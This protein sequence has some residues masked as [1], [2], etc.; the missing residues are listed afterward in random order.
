MNIN[1][2]VKKHY[3]LGCGLC[4]SDV[5]VDKLQM[6]EQSDGFPIPVPQGNFNGE[7]SG[8][9]KYCPGITV[10]LNQ[11]LRTKLEKFYGPLL[12]IKVGHAND[13]MIRFRGSSGGCLT[14]ILCELINQGKVDCVLQAG[15]SE[16]IPTRTE[17]YLSKS[18]EEI[19][20]NA[21]SRYAP[22]SLLANF[23]QILDENERIAVVG[24]PCD[25]V[26]V[27]QY[28]DIHPEYAQK[29]FCTLSFMCMGL[30]SQN[31]TNLLIEK[32]GINDPKQ[33][34]ELRYR[35][36]G[37]PGKATVVNI[38]NQIFS[39]SYNESW[40]KILG[41]DVHFRCKIC[42]DGWGSFADIS[43]GD[44]WYADSKGPVFD[45]KPGRSFVFVRSQKGKEIV[46]A[47][48]ESITL[49]DYNINQLPIIQKSQHARKSRAWS[50][51]LV[52]KI[53][54]DKLLYFKGL[55]MWDS[56]LSSN[57]LS[58]IKEAYG[59]IQR[60]NRLK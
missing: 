51:Y 47:V 17:S 41:R 25:I 58:S 33:V 56:I 29:V 4:V 50:S 23:N 46:N 20:A 12:G 37:W 44:A 11:P 52:L 36:A 27:R 43:A 34:K 48:S 59:L 13:E 21:G 39:C 55:G 30:P 54:G 24:K 60:L 22:V 49:D 31:A 8:L 26:A 32:L 53:M 5:G 18:P 28:L 35:G 9:R 14:A 2:I 38:Q 57:T 7:I 3:C 15:P 16:I 45:E 40:G 1:K 42:P 10:Q 19:I 6:V